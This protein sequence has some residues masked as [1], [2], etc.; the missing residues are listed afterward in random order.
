MLAAL[1]NS[2][3]SMSMSSMKDYIDPNMM[4]LYPHDCLFKVNRNHLL[5]SLC[6]MNIVLSFIYT[7]VIIKQKSAAIN[8]TC[9]VRK[10]LSS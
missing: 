5:K 9:L 8:L 6:V 10:I 1:R 3:D 4:E 2:P 7:Q